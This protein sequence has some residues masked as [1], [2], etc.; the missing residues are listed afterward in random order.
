MRL[1]TVREMFVFLFIWNFLF[2]FKDNENRRYFVNSSALKLSHKTMLICVK[3][4][5]ERKRVKVEED[6]Y[7]KD[8]TLILCNLCDGRR[9]TY[10]AAYE[11]ALK[12]YTCQ[13]S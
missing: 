10:L 8:I 4:L 1:F 13:Y 12:A 6:F 3:L 11:Y 2:I 5:L 9:Y 7:V